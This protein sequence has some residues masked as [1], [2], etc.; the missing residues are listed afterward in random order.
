[1]TIYCFPKPLQFLT[2]KLY[3][4]KNIHTEKELRQISKIRC[5]KLSYYKKILKVHK[6]LLSRDIV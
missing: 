2:N 3:C 4:S 5:D 1:M 6:E